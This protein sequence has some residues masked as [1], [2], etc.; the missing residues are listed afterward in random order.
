[1]RCSKLLKVVSRL[2]GVGLVS[3]A[4]TTLTSFPVRCHGC[5][6][7]PAQGPLRQYCNLPLELVIR[8]SRHIQRL[9]QFIFWSFV[10]LL[11]YSVISVV[12][13]P[14][15]R[16]S[17]AEG[18]YISWGVFRFLLC[19]PLALPNEPPRR[20]PRSILY[21]LR[22]YRVDVGSGVSPKSFERPFCSPEC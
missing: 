16:N 11:V 12:N 13:L 17:K 6:I 21:F 15:G 1:M 9:C 3:S 14:N 22:K 19:T 8:N 20:P 4:T 2:A 10:R 18:S 7:S 5:K